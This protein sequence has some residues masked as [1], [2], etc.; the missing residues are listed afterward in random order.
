MR[1]TCICQ[2]FYV[3]SGHRVSG[4]LSEEVYCL[5]LLPRDFFCGVQANI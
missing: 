5:Q 1:N 3:L 2:S 4:E